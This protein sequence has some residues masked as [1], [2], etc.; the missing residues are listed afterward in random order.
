MDKG[1]LYIKRQVG[2]ISIVSS[3]I[4]LTTFDLDFQSYLQDNGA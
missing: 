2:E 3:S 1:E 4:N